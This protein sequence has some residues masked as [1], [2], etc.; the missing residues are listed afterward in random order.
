MA[1]R[2]D[3]HPSGPMLKPASEIGD[4]DLAGGPVIPVALGL[5]IEPAGEAAT[6]RNV[7]GVSGDE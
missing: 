1:D 3:E 2:G 6:R 4:V 5:D 7:K